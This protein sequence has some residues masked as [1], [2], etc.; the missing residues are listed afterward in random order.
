MNAPGRRPALRASASRRHRLLGNGAGSGGKRRMTKRRFHELGF[1]RRF[2][3]S[4]GKAALVFAL[5]AS[6]F[7]RHLSFVIRHFL[8]TAVC[9]WT[10]RKKASSNRTDARSTELAITPRD[11]SACDS[12]SVSKAPGAQKSRSREPRYDTAVKPA[13]PSSFSRAPRKSASATSK[14]SSATA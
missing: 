3:P 9:L 12:F 6:S 11:A 10:S 14:I 7:F 2:A 13:R 1:R 4:R 5:R 8:L